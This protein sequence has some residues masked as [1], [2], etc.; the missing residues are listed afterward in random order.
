MMLNIPTNTNSSNNEAA[1]LLPALDEDLCMSFPQRLMELLNGEVY[2]DIIT[3]LPH[4]KGFIIYKK[5]KF[6]SDVLPRY[7][8]QAKFTSFTR[9]L[10]R[11]GFTRVTQRGPEFGA[12]YHKFFQRDA[13]RLC[14]QMTCE[15]GSK[16]KVQQQQQ[17]QLA[18]NDLFEPEE[19]PSVPN[20]SDVPQQFVEEEHQEQQQD[21]GSQQ[22]VSRTE[23]LRH[24]LRLRLEQER[25][26]TNSLFMQ[27]LQQKQEE[28]EQA[29]SRSGQD[30]H[31]AMEEM[32]Q[33]EPTPVVLPHAPSEFDL[34]PIH[35]EPTHP[36]EDQSVQQPVHLVDQQQAS[37]PQSVSEIC[38]R[39]QQ[40]IRALQDAQS[41]EPYGNDSNMM[42]AA[43]RF[44]NAA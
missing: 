7:F 39:L 2:D 4:G 33:H 15:S 11:W 32:Q 29:I 42:D 1:R 22:S 23:M 20:T 44:P 9:K 27:I 41:S 25:S 13:P 18:H 6:A 8:K 3:W 30:Q 36:F 40:Q 31:S 12:Y 43:R 28:L 24:Q 19:L 38:D 26:I 34:E 17:S 14:M 10:N 16:S 21:D 37:Q 5:K 35:V